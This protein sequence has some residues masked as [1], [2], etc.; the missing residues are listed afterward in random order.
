MHENLSEDVRCPG[1]DS[2]RTHTEYSSTALSLEHTVLSWQWY[3]I[4]PIN[5][6]NI[7]VSFFLVISVIFVLFKIFVVEHLCKEFKF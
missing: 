5:Y 4:K 6:L 7:L 3:I 1:R 2:R